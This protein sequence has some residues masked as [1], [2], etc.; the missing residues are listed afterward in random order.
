MVPVVKPN[1]KVRIC[2]DLR[3]FNEAAQRERYIL[4]TS[5][6]VAAKLAGAKVLSKLD[7]SSG[8]W[9][10]PESSGL[11]T[12][13]TSSGSICIRRLPLGITPTP[14]I[15]QKRMANLLKNH[16]SVAAIQD[17]IICWEKLSHNMT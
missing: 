16:N 12:F 6:N 3:K 13:I 5:E 2:V 1:S 4:L 7:V 10:H 17:D 14:D 9:Q 15:F 11:T 8:Y